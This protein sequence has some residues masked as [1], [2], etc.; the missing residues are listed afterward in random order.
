MRTLRVSEGCT[1]R[2]G[3]DRRSGPRVL[4]ARSAASAFGPGNRRGETLIWR[5][6]RGRGGGLAVS[7]VRD[8]EVDTPYSSVLQVRA[9]RRPA[10]PG[11]GG[12]PKRRRSWSW[13][14]VPEPL[15][16]SLLVGRLRTSLRELMK[17]V[18]DVHRDHTRHPR[19][20]EVPGA[21]QAGL[22]AAR[23]A[24][25]PSLLPGDGPRPGCLPLRGALRGRA[26]RLPRREARRFEHPALLPGRGGAR[27]GAARPRA[28]LR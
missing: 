21:R 9:S 2:S 11:S 3:T 6:S 22:S 25:R 12:P 26:P 4:L 7:F 16:R 15:R 8:R 20:G 1:Y 10:S 28:G 13:R 23:G 24:S 5:T 18:R 17:E 14:P 19:P 27:H